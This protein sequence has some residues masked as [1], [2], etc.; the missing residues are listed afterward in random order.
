MFCAEELPED[1]VFRVVIAVDGLDTVIPT[2][3]IAVTLESALDA[4]DRLNRRLGHD[5]R[6]SWT[7]FVANLQRTATTH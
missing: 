3:M 6:A 2:S 5:D 7:A 4:C 1:E